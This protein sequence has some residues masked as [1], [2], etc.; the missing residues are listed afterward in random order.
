MVSEKEK[1]DGWEDRDV[2]MTQLGPALN[3][4]TPE[5]LWCV[6]EPAEHTSKPQASHYIEGQHLS[7]LYRLSIKT[8]VA[9]GLDM[10]IA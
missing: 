3:F 7:L 1:K 8:M 5:I 2:D 4:M 10:K 6:S 9:G